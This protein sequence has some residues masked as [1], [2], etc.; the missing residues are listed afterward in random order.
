M[1]VFYVEKAGVWVGKGR[2]E[3][4]EGEECGWGGVGR[5]VSLLYLSVVLSI[6]FLGLSPIYNASQK[7]LLTM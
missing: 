4:G 7:H 1:C 3:G 6:N 2:S 5:V